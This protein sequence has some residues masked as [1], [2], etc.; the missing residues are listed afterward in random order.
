MVTKAQVLEA[1]KEVYDPEF[2]VSVVDLGLIYDV[3]IAK[4]RVSVIMTLTN[5]GCPM[6]AVITQMVREKVESLK[7]VKE[8]DIDLVFEPRW[9]PERMSDEAKKKFGFA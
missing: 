9:T 3:K 5:P 8:A 2:P 7:G 1:L 6:S 4:D